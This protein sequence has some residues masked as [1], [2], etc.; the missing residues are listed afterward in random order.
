MKKL[1]LVGSVLF[2]AAIVAIIIAVGRRA[3]EK[4][5]APSHLRRIAA[6][7]N[8]RAPMDAGGM[9]EV[10]AAESDATSLTV[11]YQLLN[12]DAAKVDATGQRAAREQLRQHSCEKEDL[13]ELLD[14]G[15]TLHYVLVDMKNVPILST[16]ILR[17]ECGGGLTAPSSR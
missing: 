14:N 13:R 9:L 10:T 15:V 16:D 2:A 17:W 1:F 11:H 8:A 5:G 4:P 3:F 7:I 12:A 6:Q